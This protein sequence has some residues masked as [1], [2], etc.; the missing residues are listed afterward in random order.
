M[1]FYVF[2]FFVQRHQ[3]NCV[4]CLVCR[5]PTYMYVQRDVEPHGNCSSIRHTEILA[6]HV[7]L[8]GTTTGAMASRRP[9]SVLG[10]QLKPNAKPKTAKPPNKWRVVRG[11]LVRV[12]SCMR[13]AT[14]ASAMWARGRGMDGI[15]ERARH[16][17]RPNAVLLM[18][19][20]GRGSG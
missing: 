4:A 6:L 13:A 14:D 5:R 17:A 11:D 18:L 1:K 2:F 16:P 7:N 15:P 19:W 20:L 8:S 9:W 3:I 12:L 10:R